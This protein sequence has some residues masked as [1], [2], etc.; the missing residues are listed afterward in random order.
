MKLLLSRTT[1]FNSSR[2]EHL[3]N[4]VLSA[5][6]S[7]VFGRVRPR[8]AVFTTPN[9]EF[10]PLFAD[11]PGPFRHWDHRFEW[12][13]S[14]HWKKES[15]TQIPRKKSPSPLRKRAYVQGHAAQ[16]IY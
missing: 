15:Q 1:L 16:F 9:R 7:V 4:D 12:T 11:F 6:P 5:L 14:A 3:P 13:R 10:N 8:V 2:I